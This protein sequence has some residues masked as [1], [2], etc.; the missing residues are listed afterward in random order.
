MHGQLNVKLVHLVGFIISQQ[1]VA[2]PTELQGPHTLQLHYSTKREA[3]KLI[4][5]EIFIKIFSIRNNLN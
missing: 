3:V 1:S 2:I 5:D 4:H